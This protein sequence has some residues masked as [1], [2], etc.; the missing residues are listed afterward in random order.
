MSQNADSVKSILY[1]LGANFSIA[2][3]KLVAAVITS[4]GAMLAEAIHSLADTGNQLLLLLG[5]RHSKRPPTADYPLGYGKSIYFWSFLVALMLFSIGGLFSVYEGTHKLLHPEQVNSPMIAIGVLLFA[6]VAEGIS[7]WGC[8]N[9]VAKV[10]NGRSL[11][12]WFRESRQSELL[13]IFGEDLAAL[14]GLILALLAISLSYVT[15][16]PIYDA[17]G[18]I[19]IGVLLIVVAVFIGIEVK[20]LLI[21]Q[22]VEQHVHQQM[23][24]F[25]AGRDE[26][27]EVFNLLSMQ[28]GDRVMVAV[29]ARMAEQSDAA[30]LVTDINTVEAAF[31]VEFPAVMWLFF[32][33]DNKR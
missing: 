9:E 31:R 3:A 29:K 25:L 2:I 33:P 6:I 1:A 30:R 13:V 20:A 8:L 4:S 5:L 32:E 14:L 26:V 18:T 17:C 27:A 21:G 22:G 19:A 23:V 24:G 16:N 15:G 7:M 11:I 10:R 12:R 28:L